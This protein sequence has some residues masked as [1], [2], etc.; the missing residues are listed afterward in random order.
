MGH[1]FE[2]RFGRPI[3]QIH[4]KWLT[5]GDTYEVEIYNEDFE[6]TIVALVIAID[7]VAGSSSLA[8]PVAV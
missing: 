5:W 2:N 6:E 3:A 7:C 1:G 8:V 4:K